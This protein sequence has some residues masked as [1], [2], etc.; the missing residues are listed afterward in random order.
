MGRRQSAPAN[1]RVRGQRKPPRNDWWHDGRWLPIVGDVV[2]VHTG[3]EPQYWPYG[4][5]VRVFDCN[6]GQR[7]N[8]EHFDPG[9][10]GPWTYALLAIRPSVMT[11][12]GPRCADCGQLQP[13]EQP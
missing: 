9:N 2:H 10:R 4:R 3:S 7:W 1:W 12:A 8:V 11:A 5:V 6:Y 13:E